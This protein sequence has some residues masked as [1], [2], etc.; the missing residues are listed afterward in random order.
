MVGGPECIGEV[1]AH[2]NQDSHFG[3]LLMNTR[4]QSSWLQGG[5]FPSVTRSLL[6][7]PAGMAAEE[8]SSWVSVQSYGQGG[9]ASQSRS[10]SKESLRITE[11]P[12][13]SRAGAQRHCV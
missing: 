10:R 3:G 7:L 4:L 5:S 9:E 11:E 8:G 1:N 6:L 13:S 2:T 12:G